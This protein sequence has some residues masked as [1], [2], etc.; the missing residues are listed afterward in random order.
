ME[1]LGEDLNNSFGC[2]MAYCY[3]LPGDDA[4][5]LPC[6]LL[7]WAN[8]V[9]W[10]RNELIINVCHFNMRPWHFLFFFWIAVC[11]SYVCF[12]Y[13]II[14]SGESITKFFSGLYMEQFP[15]IGIN[16]K[17]L[18]IWSHSYRFFLQINTNNFQS[19]LR[20]HLHLLKYITLLLHIKVV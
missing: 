16:C 6:D 14:L 13:Y 17:P 3:L 19:H 7:S 11:Q 18:E 12:I 5:L 4:A 20:N 10:T 1:F 15:V 9:H 8:N 2:W